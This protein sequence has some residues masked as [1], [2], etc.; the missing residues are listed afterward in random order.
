M[1][2]GGNIKLILALKL[3]G[4]RLEFR[5]DV[6]QIDSYSAWM[7]TQVGC[8]ISEEANEMNFVRISI[9]PTSIDLQ[10]RALLMNVVRPTTH[11]KIQ[12]LYGVSPFPVDCLVHR[13]PLVPEQQNKIPASARVHQSHVFADQIQ[14]GPVDEKVKLEWIPGGFRCN[15]Y[16]MKHFDIKQCKPPSLYAYSFLRSS[17]EVLSVL[18]TCKTK[19]NRYQVT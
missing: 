16:R 6:R 1:L 18:L 14:M 7:V 9:L 4:C 13:L 2:H 3:H 11:A 17:I 5:R 19:R 8:G 12:T 10:Q 15:I